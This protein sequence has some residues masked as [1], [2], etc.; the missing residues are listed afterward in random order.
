MKHP[1]IELLEATH[2]FPGP[3]LFKLVGDNGVLLETALMELISRHAT[4]AKLVGTR[5]SSSG[6]HVSFSIEA[7]VESAQ[8]VHDILTALHAMPGLAMI[9]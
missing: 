6:K 8:T 3:Y 2:T 7:Q 1:P 9:L 5:H 4:E